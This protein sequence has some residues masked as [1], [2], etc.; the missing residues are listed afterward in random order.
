MLYEHAAAR[1]ERHTFDVVVL[2]DAGL[3]VVDAAVA[4]RVRQSDGHLADD[5]RSRDVL[6]EERRR[7]LENVR[8]VVEAVALVVLRQKRLDVHVEREQIGDRVR[9]LGSI[10]TMQGD[11][12]GVPRRRRGGVELGLEARDPGTSRRAIRLRRAGRRHLRAAQLAHGG[13]EDAGLVRDRLGGHAIERD[14]GRQVVAV[15]AIGAI[16]AKQGPLLRG[17]RRRAV[18]TKPSDAAAESGDGR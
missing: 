2:V 10:Q 7:D 1:A 3:R 17:A 5:A 13:L 15:V 8:D 6:L 14:L 9:V 18:H 4:L 16:L 11:F 12:T